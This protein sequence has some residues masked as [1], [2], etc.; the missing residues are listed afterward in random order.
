MTYDRDAPSNVSITLIFLFVSC[1]ISKQ[2]LKNS[3]EACPGPPSGPPT[4]SGR[5]RTSHPGSALFTE[6]NSKLE[7]L[8]QCMPPPRHVFQ[9]RDPDPSG[10]VTWI[11]TKNLF[12]CSMA[13]CQPSLKI[14]CKSVQKF[15]RKVANRHRDRQTDK[16]RLHILL[17][18]GS[19]NSDEPRFFSLT[20]TAPTFT[21][22]RITVCRSNTAGIFL[23]KPDF[24]QFQRFTRA[25]G[26]PLV[27]SNETA[28]S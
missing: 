14:S 6:N 17:G 18:G 9:C 20:T 2:V 21:R 27:L 8:K 4:F 3:T 5:T 28:P 7:A 1:S 15:L 11:A 12:I 16:Q 25:K 26:R 13:H 22:L 10:S 24:L 19:H 23:N